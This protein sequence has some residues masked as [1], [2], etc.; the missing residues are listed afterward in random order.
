MS[1]SKW[2]GFFQEQSILKID[3]KKLNQRYN[4]KIWSRSSV[5]SSKFVSKW[6]AIN[7]GNGFKRFLVTSEHLGY[8]FGE[9]AFTR[10]YNHKPKIKNKKTK[11]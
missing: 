5:I 7:K 1:R 11:R 9:F 6:V 3:S 10:V 4:V 8:K 2:K